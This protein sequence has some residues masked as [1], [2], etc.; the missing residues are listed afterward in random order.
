MV[1]TVETDKLYQLSNKIK[2]LQRNFGSLL[3]LDPKVSETRKLAKVST[4]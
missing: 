2:V 4:P 1:G 3:F